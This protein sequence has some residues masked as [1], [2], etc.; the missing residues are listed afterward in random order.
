MDPSLFNSTPMDPLNAT[1]SSP[2]TCRLSSLVS[3]TSVRSNR[4]LPVLFGAGAAV[5]PPEAICLSHSV[6]L[7]ALSYTVRNPPSQSF[8]MCANLKC[9]RTFVSVHSI[10]ILVYGHTQTDRQTY[11]CVLQCSHASVGLAQAHPN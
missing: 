8:S 7:S 3:L 9:T 4:L 11:T 6:H 10:K 2:C 5:S 1:D